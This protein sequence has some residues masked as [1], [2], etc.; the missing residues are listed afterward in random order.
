MLRFDQITIVKSQTRRATFVI[1]FA[2]KL[3][4][5]FHVG[6]LLWKV[7]WAGGVKGSCGFGARRGALPFVERGTPP[8]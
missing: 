7:G 8:A 1:F 6:F 4:A 2:W 5:K 3:V